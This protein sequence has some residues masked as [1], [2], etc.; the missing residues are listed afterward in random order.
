LAQAQFPRESYAFILS[1]DSLFR[2]AFLDVFRSAEAALRLQSRLG[3]ESNR[4]VLV[5]ILA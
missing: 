1:P 3:A 5:L 2:F 4:E